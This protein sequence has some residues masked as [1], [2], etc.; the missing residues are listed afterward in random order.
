MEIEVTVKNLVSAAC[1]ALGLGALGM[2]AA[3]AHGS[4]TPKHGGIVQ[5]VGDLG[6]EL[7]STADGVA[8]Y[9]DDHGKPVAPAGIAGK[10]TVLNGTQ[11][12]E[13]DLVA[14]GDR[15]EAK[16]IKLTKGAK[17]VAALTT[18]QKKAVTVRFTVR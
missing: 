5:T 18:A 13:A 3:L 7:V 14:A 17:V 15:L 11:K 10:L 6:F 4:A 1:L 12:S 8:L 16:G 9:V 2:P